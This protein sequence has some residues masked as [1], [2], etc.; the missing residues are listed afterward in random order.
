M[1][2]QQGDVAAG[3]V[4][5]AG[6]GQQS[7]QALAVRFQPAA[8]WVMAWGCAGFASCGGGRWALGWRMPGLTRDKKPQLVSPE[9]VVELPW[10]QGV[11]QGGVLNVRAIA[12]DGRTVTGTVYTL[13]DF[14]GPVPVVWHCR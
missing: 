4:V 9:A 2:A 6:L 14:R 3:A 1:G 5:N 13:P 12:A 7:G 11:A 8:G 10:P